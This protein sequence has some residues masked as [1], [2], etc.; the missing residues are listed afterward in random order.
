[1]DRFG[2][3]EELKK[4]TKELSIELD[5]QIELKNKLEYRIEETNKLNINNAIRYAIDIR[6]GKDESDSG[7]IDTSLSKTGKTKKR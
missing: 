7:R 4:T 1:M 3:Y 5:K 6:Q 2:L